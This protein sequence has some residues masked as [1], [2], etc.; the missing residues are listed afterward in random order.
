M[1]RVTKHFT[2]GPL[3]G[4]EVTETTAVRFEVGKSYQACTGGSAYRVTACWPA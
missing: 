4:L 2:K 1:Y 3:K